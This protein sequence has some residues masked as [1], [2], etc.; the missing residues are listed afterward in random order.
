VEIRWFNPDKDDAK[1]L[2]ELNPFNEVWQTWMG[3]QYEAYKPVLSGSM[4]VAED[5]G[6]LVGAMHVFDCGLPWTILDGWYLKPEYRT[7]AN[8]RLMAE[9][10]IKMLQARG[11][12]MVQINATGALAKILEKRYNFRALPFD[13][14]M[15]IKVI[16]N[17]D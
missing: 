10:A 1:A 12:Q 6:K 15:L 13:F 14:K 11:I 7:M 16:Y 17:G 2:G 4:I 8:A 9:S 5:A 3:K